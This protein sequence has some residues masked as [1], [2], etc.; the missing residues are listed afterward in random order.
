VI[1]RL[2]KVRSGTPLGD[3]K[4]DVNII[5]DLGEAGEL[6]YVALRRTEEQVRYFLQFVRRNTD[7]FKELVSLVQF[8]WERDVLLTWR[9]PRNRRLK[10]KDKSSSTD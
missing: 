5:T 10:S 3:W 1:V 2:D 6:H 9:A 7:T 8:M 4:N